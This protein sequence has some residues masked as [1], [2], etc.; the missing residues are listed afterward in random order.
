MQVANLGTNILGLE[1]ANVITINQTAD[2][3]N[4]YVHTRAP[5]RARR[6]VWQAPAVKSLPDRKVRPPGELTS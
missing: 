1:A 6:S 4:W 3:Y 2:G 5:A